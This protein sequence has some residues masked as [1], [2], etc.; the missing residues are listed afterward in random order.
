M[1]NLPLDWKTKVGLKLSVNK[2]KPKVEN[3]RQAGVVEKLVRSKSKIWCGRGGK[4]EMTK[5][6]PIQLGQKSKAGLVLLVIKNAH[7]LKDAKKGQIGQAGFENLVSNK[8]FIGCG[9]QGWTRIRKFNPIQL[10]FPNFLQFGQTRVVGV[11][12]NLL[13]LKSFAET[14]V[15]WESCVCWMRSVGI[16]RLAKLVQTFNPRPA[17]FSHR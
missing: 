15:K 12:K 6:S 1:E 5:F 8:K 14:K 13:K 7:K 3:I 17:N 2:M 10:L 11:M 16:S 9:V 4:G